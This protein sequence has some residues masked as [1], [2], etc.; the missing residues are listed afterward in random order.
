MPN[1]KCQIPAYRDNSNGFFTE[2]SKVAAY[3]IKRF[4]TPKTTTLVVDEY[5]KYICTQDYNVHSIIVNDILDDLYE[6]MTI[7]LHLGNYGDRLWDYTLLIVDSF[8]AFE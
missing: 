3:L 2:Y 5:C 6:H 1:I 8:Y 7:Q 4:I